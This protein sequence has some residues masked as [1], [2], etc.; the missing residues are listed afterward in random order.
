M[1]IVPVVA[2]A[3]LTS[4]CASLDARWDAQHRGNDYQCGNA[5]SSD[6]HYSAF[7]GRQGRSGCGADYAAAA[8][9]HEVITEGNAMNWDMIE[10]NWK[11]FRG[12][13]RE[14]WGRLTDDHLDLIAGKRDQLSRQIQ[15]RYGIT[16]DQAERWLKLFEENHKDFQPTSTAKQGSV[17]A[18]EAKQRSVL[19]G[20]FA[21]VAKR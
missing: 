14:Q 3:A 16:K 6:G 17:L 18:T 19:A 7:A 12:H 1:L 11:Q 20:R 2:A 8:V 21:S 4:G 10:D 15:A 9:A 5:A 13:V